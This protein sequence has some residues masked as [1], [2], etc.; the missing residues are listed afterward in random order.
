MTILIAED[1]PLLR[2]LLTEILTREPGFEV[3]GSVATGPECLAAVTDARPDVLLLDLR[4][5]VRSGVELLERLGDVAE[6]LVLSDDLD[7][8]AALAAARS[9]ARGYLAKSQALTLLPQAIRAVA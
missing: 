1:D 7:E 6:V 8:Q 2:S 4:A 5:P 3:A 9:G